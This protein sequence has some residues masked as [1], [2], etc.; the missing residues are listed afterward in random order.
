MPIFPADSCFVY[1]E[2][3]Q[4]PDARFQAAAAIR[5]AAIREWG[6]LTADD[7]RSLLRLT[8]MLLFLLTL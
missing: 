2:N 4:V 3:S 7:R 5:D 6:F 1:P 8:Y